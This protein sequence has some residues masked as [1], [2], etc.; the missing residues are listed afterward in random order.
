MTT[1]PGTDPIGI[2][3]TPRAAAHV[4]RWL[5]GRDLRLRVK[6]TGCSGYAYVVEP[7]ESI[8]DAD[9]LLECE[10]VRIVVDRVS[11]PFL[12]GTQV[13]YVREGLNA[14]FEFRNPNVTATCGCGES[15]SV[16]DAAGSAR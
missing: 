6:T 12:R 8:A 1:T 7:S 2:T 14:H 13:D 4:R 16:A 3:L 10:G 5:G 9:S 11:L 15:F